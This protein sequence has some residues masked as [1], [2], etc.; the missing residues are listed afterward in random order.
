MDEDDD[1]SLNL[2]LMTIALRRFGDNILDNYHII[3]IQHLLSDTITFT[4]QIKQK[5]AS[6]TIIGIPYWYDHI[7]IQE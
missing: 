7:R 4:S 1:L 6:V 3:L 5:G 2:P